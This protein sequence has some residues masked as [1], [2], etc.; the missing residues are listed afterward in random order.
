MLLQISVF[1]QYEAET[2]FL[3]G[4]SVMRP[5]QPAATTHKTNPSSA[6]QQQS[7]TQLPPAP[8]DLPSN[9]NNPQ[10]H[11]STQH[12]FPTGRP[13]SGFALQQKQAIPHSQPSLID[14]DNNW[15]AKGA[16]SV[17]SQ[18][19]AEGNL[20]DFGGES[21]N[22]APAVDWGFTTNQMPAGNPSNT[23]SQMLA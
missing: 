18:S 9:P 21:G 17:A 1:V 23:S 14:F 4:H 13:D 10:S 3:K 22:N 11:L 8:T 5:L 12:A 19:C 7:H 6:S 16:A 2:K 15:T 20:I